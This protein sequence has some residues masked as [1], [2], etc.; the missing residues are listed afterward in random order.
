ML[1][2]YDSL[3]ESL[4]R[5]SLGH[6]KRGREALE[7]MAQGFEAYY[8]SHR[9]K[10]YQEAL[11]NSISPDSDFWANFLGDILDYVDKY[12]K[13]DTNTYWRIVMGQLSRRELQLLFYFALQ[14]E[15]SSL[16]TI[17]EGHG[18]FQGVRDDVLV[19]KEDRQLYSANAFGEES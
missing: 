17:I 16:K 11:K 19:R 4:R 2:H 3:L 8:S 6:E 1:H 14:P 7:D 18:L 12:G 15:K 9:N 13:S 5:G 10:G